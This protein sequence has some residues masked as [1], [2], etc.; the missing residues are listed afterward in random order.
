MSNRHV[1]LGHAVSLAKNGSLDTLS[2]V[3]SAKEFLAFLETKDAPEPFATGAK[4][5]TALAPYR[6]FRS[7]RGTVGA[8]RA[9]DGASPDTVVE[10]RS[11][12]KWVPSPAD[13]TVQDLF[14]DGYTWAPVEDPRGIDHK[15]YVYFRKSDYL[16]RVT[17]GDGPNAPAEYLSHF[18]DTWRSSGETYESLGGYTA[19]FRPEDV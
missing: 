5:E 4:I 15:K 8:F 10:W 3:T 1:A 2:I 18:S 14:D 12:D 17:I 13:T 19:V 6:G 9:R 11:S 7:Q 16:Y